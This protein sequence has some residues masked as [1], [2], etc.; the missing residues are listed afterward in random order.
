MTE[1][2]KYLINEFKLFCFRYNVD[3]TKTLLSLMDSFIEDFRDPERSVLDPKPAVYKIRDLNGD[4]RRIECL[5]LYDCTVYG[6]P[7]CAIYYDDL[8]MRVPMEAIELS[9]ADHIRRTHI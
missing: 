7:R 1:K 3:P 6:Q 2:D 8:F 9:N 4:E 5:Y